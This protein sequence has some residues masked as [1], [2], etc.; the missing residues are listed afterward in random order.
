MLY[1]K[2]IILLFSLLFIAIQL[3]LSQNTSNIWGY[4]AE[5]DDSRL[6]E[7]GG[8]GFPATNYDFV[9]VAMFVPGIPSLIGST[10][11]AIRLPIYPFPDQYK[12]DCRESLSKGSLWLS[13]NLSNRIREEPITTFEE[14]K[15]CEVTL[16]EPYTITS[17]GIYAG[18]SFPN[19]NT[20]IYAKTSS[21]ENGFYIRR[22]KGE[23]QTEKEEILPLQIRVENSNIPNCFAYFGTNNSAV[24]IAGKRQQVD[25]VVYTEGSER[26]KNIEYTA[27]V[28]GVEQKGKL[29]KTIYAGYK[30][31][32]TVN[33]PITAP[34]NISPYELKLTINKV[35][36]EDNDAEELYS[37]STINNIPYQ[38]VRNSIVEE[39]TGT[40]CGYCPRGIVGMRRAR[41]IYGD[42]FIGIAQHSSDIMSINYFDLA[43]SG[44]PSCRIDRGEIIDPHFYGDKFTAFDLAQTKEPDVDIQIEAVWNDDK[45]SV[46]ITTETLFLG[47]GNNYSIAYVLT[48]DSLHGTTSSW[49][50]RNFYSGSSSS[51]PELQEFCDMP[52]V[53]EGLYFNDVAIASSYSA[54]G[55]NMAEG[56]PSIVNKEDKI[57][58]NYAL[59]LPASGELHDAVNKNYVYAIAIVTKP[60]GSVANAAKTL[61]VDK[62]MS[63]VRYVSEDE[64]GIAGIRYYTLNGAVVEN[65]SKG[66]FLKKTTYKNGMIKT[67]KV[68][69]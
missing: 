63:D 18:L 69:N 44:I 56:F 64:I 14:G 7:L 46:N 28:D 20:W 17:K 41:E 66:I 42:R 33:I 49:S 47:S 43:F 4:F 61:V 24:T 5:T 50:Q 38:V 52:S 6:S 13:T 40:W 22:N 9:D 16:K 45:E 62:S 23:W 10:I 32:G 39:G 67:E 11:T 37:V 30:N 54:S 60:D 53:I 68:K 15:F 8:I 3:V 35:N 57:T 65:P 25:V 19:K 58:K 29:N 27:I 12:N 36:G 59:S 55:Q 26:I 51:D 48:A 2:T 31:S 34:N 21:M 1:K